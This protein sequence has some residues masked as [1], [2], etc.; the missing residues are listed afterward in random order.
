MWGFIIKADPT[1]LAYAVPT[2]IMWIGYL[3]N[4]IYG[5]ILWVKRAKG[6]VN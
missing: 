3:V 4:S 1:S 6:R 5:L 2:M